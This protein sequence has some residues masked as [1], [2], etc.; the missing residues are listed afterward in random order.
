MMM[1]EPPLAV[2][3]GCR[4]RT[5]VSDID[6]LPAQGEFKVESC[7]PAGQAFHP[8]LACV[9]LDNP[10]SHREAQTRAPGLAFPRRGLGG[11]KLIVDFVDVFG[12][13]ARAGVAD[14]YLDAGA[15]AGADAKR[16]DV[17][18]Y[19]ILGVDEQI[20][21]YLLHLACVPVDQ[22]KIAVEIGFYLDVRS[23]ELVLEQVESVGDDLVDAHVIELGGAGAGE[24]QQ[25]I[26]DL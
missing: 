26:D 24:V 16:A 18:S 20:Q 6:G 4:L 1:T 21:K 5:A 25:V 3:A 2:A 11:E 19:R 15:V 22:G 23:L 10:V 9:F 14:A 13:D 12:R 8:D 17:S 7:A